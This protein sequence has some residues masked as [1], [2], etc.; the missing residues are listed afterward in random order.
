MRRLDIGES[1]KFKNKAEKKVYEH[2]SAKFQHLSKLYDLERYHEIDDQIDIFVKKLQTLSESVRCKLSYKCYALFIA[3]LNTYGNYEYGLQFC[4][5]WENDIIIEYGSSSM[6]YLTFLQGKRNL[7]SYLKNKND[8]MATISAQMIDVTK[9]CYGKGSFEHCISIAK[10]ILY[11]NL[12]NRKLSTQDIF[13]HISYAYKICKND[14]VFSYFST[15]QSAYYENMK[16]YRYALRLKKIAIKQLEIALYT[17]NKNRIPA[18]DLI[19]AYEKLGELYYNLE[20]FSEAKSYYVK[21]VNHY[22]D[23]HQKESNDYFNRITKV[24]AKIVD[25]ANNHKFCKNCPNC[26]IYVAYG[27]ESPLRYRIERSK[28]FCTNCHIVQDSMQVCK[29][30]RDTHYCSEKC[31]NEHWYIHKHDC[32]IDIKDMKIKKCKH[33]NIASEEMDYCS[34][35]GNTY[36][37]SEQCQHKDW[38]LHKIFCNKI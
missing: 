22:L 13:K 14:S 2:L 38:Q 12:I 27:N 37:C 15:M 17:D 24:F 5:P 34:G 8:D 1:L 3:T 31:Q 16:N 10:H 6:E 20:R 18:I 9:S 32:S 19:V 23:R 21:V 11:T 36:Y 30:C 25:F 33:C 29:G 4:T 7:L 26:S 35:C 28:K